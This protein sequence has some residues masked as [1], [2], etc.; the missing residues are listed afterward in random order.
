M[1]EYTDELSA[2]VKVTTEWDLDPYWKNNYWWRSDEPKLISTTQSRP[3]AEWGKEN[4]L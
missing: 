4:E 1:S 3:Y 2:T